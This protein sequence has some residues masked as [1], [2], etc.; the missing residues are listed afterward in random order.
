[1]RKKYW[2]GKDTIR[3]DFGAPAS[4]PKSGT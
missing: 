1:L 3:P 4:K 2:Q